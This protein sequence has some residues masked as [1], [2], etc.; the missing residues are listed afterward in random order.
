M[1]NANTWNQEPDLAALRRAYDLLT[2]NPSQAIQDLK[3][4]AAAGSAA[5]MLYLGDMYENGKYVAKDLKQSEYWFNHAYKLGNSEGLFYLGR[6]YFR[7]E[8]YSSA[9][10]IFLEGATKND[11]YSMQWLARIYLIRNEK[12]NDAKLLFEKAAAGGS[13]RA[14]RFLGGILLR[15]GYGL[16]GFFRGLWLTVHAIFEGF[17]TAKNDRTSRRLR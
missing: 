2:V 4:L 3:A 8:D 10:K 6:L 12:I 16:T 5:S 14:E 13:I 1:S 15:G 17:I 9:E 7:Q 11:P